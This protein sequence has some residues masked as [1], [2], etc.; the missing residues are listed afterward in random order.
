MGLKID[1]GGPLVPNKSDLS[2]FLN[3]ELNFTFKSTH[4]SLKMVF[5][6]TLLGLYISI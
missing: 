4:I 3:K 5:G 6:S 1:N 2:W